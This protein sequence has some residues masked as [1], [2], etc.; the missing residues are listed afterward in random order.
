MDKNQN[1]QLMLYY[2]YLILNFS[3]RISFMTLIRKDAL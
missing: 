3:K 2:K 1:Y